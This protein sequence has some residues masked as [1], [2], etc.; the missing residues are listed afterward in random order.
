MSIVLPSIGIGFITTLQQIDPF[1]IDSS[2]IATESD[3]RAYTTASLGDV[4][5]GTDT[6]SLY[7]F[8][9]TDAWVK[10]NND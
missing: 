9:G 4:A 7:I 1:L 6:N 2:L 3:I 5:Y 10:F 8:N